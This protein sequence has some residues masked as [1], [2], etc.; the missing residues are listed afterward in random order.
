MKHRCLSA[1][2]WRVQRFG[3]AHQSLLGESNTR[4]T[5][6]RWNMTL[7]GGVPEKSKRNNLS[8]F[9]HD[10]NTSGSFRVQWVLRHYQYT[11]PLQYIWQLQCGEYFFVIR[12]ILNVGDY[13]LLFYVHSFLFFFFFPLFSPPY[14]TRRHYANR[15]K[16]LE[17]GLQKTGGEKIPFLFPNFPK[18]EE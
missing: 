15:I 8:S 6:T 5:G 7:C 14:I 13:F 17:I 10:P 16:K 18:L 9:L 11:R 4:H 1:I 3:S 2:G 12:A